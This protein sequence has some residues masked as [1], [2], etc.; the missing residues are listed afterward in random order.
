MDIVFVKYQKTVRHIHFIAD[1]IP[2]VLEVIFNGKIPHVKPVSGNVEAIGAVVK[3]LEHYIDPLISVEQPEHT[4]FITAMLGRFARLLTSVGT[5]NK[6]RWTETV[7][8]SREKLSSIS[9][10]KSVRQLLTLCLPTKLSREC[11]TLRTDIFK[12]SI[13]SR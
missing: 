11:K 12:N 9:H 4:Q 13:S 10:T 3:H 6:K 7:Y 2:V 8:D 5:V 1:N